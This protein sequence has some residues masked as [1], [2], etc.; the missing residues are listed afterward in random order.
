MRNRESYE[1]MDTDDISETGPA[2]CKCYVYR[3]L[4]PYNSRSIGSCEFYDTPSP[5]ESCNLH[6]CKLYNPLLPPFQGLVD[7]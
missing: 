5:R 1:S 4:S 3:P 6:L 7:Y 2:R